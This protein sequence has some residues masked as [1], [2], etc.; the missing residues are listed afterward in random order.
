MGSSYYI[1]ILKW[2][3]KLIL[4]SCEG[5]VVYFVQGQQPGF[6]YVTKQNRIHTSGREE[7][8]VVH[9]N[10]SSLYCYQGEMNERRWS[11]IR[12]TRERKEGKIKSAFLTLPAS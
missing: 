5:L 6:I 8:N 2:P 4:K 7:N 9:F 12:L 10:L 3:N 11:D 1:P